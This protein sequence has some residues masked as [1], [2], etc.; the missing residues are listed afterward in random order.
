MANECR[1]GAWVFRINPSDNRQLQ[2]ATT[3]SFSLVWTAPNGERILDIH[4]H[5]DDVVI[6]TDRH[7][8]QRNKSGVI[9]LR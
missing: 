3:G 5:G 7:S 8:Y 2:R 4:A 9:S 6:E 1:V